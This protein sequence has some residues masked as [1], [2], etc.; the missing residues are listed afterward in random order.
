MVPFDAPPTPPRR[1]PRFHPPVSLRRSTHL[2]PDDDAN[3]ILKIRHNNL[4]GDNPHV[5]DPERDF[6]NEMKF[7][8]P[9]KLEEDPW[10]I[11][12]IKTHRFHS[13]VPGTQL[14]FLISYQC[15][16][17][18]QWIPYQNVLDDEPWLVNPVPSY[19]QT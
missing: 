6:M 8:D 13:T 12:K 9:W 19:K 7:L 16:D 4:T 17:E 14:E 1:S 11:A 2:T 3:S 10:D 18:E 5:D 15:D